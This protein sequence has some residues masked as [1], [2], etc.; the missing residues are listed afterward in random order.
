MRQ[1]LPIDV[2]NAGKQRISYLFDKFQNVIVNVSGGK[3][4]TVILDLAMKEAEKRDRLPLKVFFIDQE[5]EWT[6][7]IEWMRKVMYDERVEPIW[8][9]GEFRIINATTFTGERYLWCWKEGEN[10]LREKEEIAIKKNIYGVYDFHPLFEAIRDY[11]WKH[12]KTAIIYGLRA[13]ENPRRLMA[14]TNALA[15]KNISWGK[16]NINPLHFN[17]SPIYDWSYTDVWKYIHEN[18]LEYN[19]IYD[20]QFMNGIPIQNMRVSNLHHE[21]A[22]RNLEYLPVADIELY[23][24]LVERLKGVHSYLKCY[25]YNISL[26]A[27]FKDWKE[28]RDYLLDKLVPENKKEFMLNYFKRI[29]KKF[30]EDNYILKKECEAIIKSDW[31]E[32]TNLK[33]LIV[34][35]DRKEYERRI[36]G[37]NKKRI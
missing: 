6:Y 20:L 11:H 18:R 37:N 36:K 15:Y 24:K 19:K 2:V 7:T 10:W 35:L 31:D 28:Y 16:K 29:K 23:N 4:S 12:E 21:T 3:D 32:G 34:F 14:M 27:V 30:G 17:F 5:A 25:H 13:E 9:Q 1:Y 26:P 22:L 33:N 8:F